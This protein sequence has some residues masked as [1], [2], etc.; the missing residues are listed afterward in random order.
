MESSMSAAALLLRDFVNTLDV[1]CGADEIGTPAGLAGWLGERG[2]L[3]GPVAASADELTL[4]T[5]F[6]EGLRAAMLG[7]QRATAG[8]PPPDLDPD[9]DQALARLPLRVSLDAPGPGLVP[10]GGGVAAGLGR[11][12]AA[13]MECVADGTWTR[14][15]ACREHTCRWVFVDTSKNR[16]R[17]WCSM[18][19]CG[20]RTKTRAYRARRRDSSDTL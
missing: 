6:R 12:A 20:N 8:G 2:L 19:V 1:E 9:L 7:H 13:V 4:A 3:A 10:A 5:T 16:S 18:R 15:K 14:L 11:L 17:A